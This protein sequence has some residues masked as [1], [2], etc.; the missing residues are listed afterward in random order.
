MQESGPKSPKGDAPDQGQKARQANEK[1]APPAASAQVRRP[2]RTADP[3]TRWLTF[4]ILGLIILAL[5]GVVSAVVFGVINPG[6]PPRTASERDIDYFSGLV[7]SGKADSKAYAQYVDT[8]IRA[9]QLSKA[10]Q[11]LDR[12]MQTAKKDKSYLYAEQAQLRLVQKDYQ[13][14]AT[15]ADTAMAEA[16]KELKAFMAANVAAN[17]RADAGATM[18]DSYSTAALAKASALIAS[19]DYA[20]AIKAYDTYLKVQPIDSDVLVERGFAKAQ[21]G[22]K[23][24]AAADYRAALKYIPDY[25]PAL[26]GLKQIGA[27]K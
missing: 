6:G 20:N 11:A 8:L 2:Q 15:A 27:A 19:K 5:A 13:G 18:P 17:R 7:Q 12:A 14:T 10:E 25:Q 4:V 9:G 22:D 1:A 23:T 26:D 16:Q 3:V 24:G 21:V